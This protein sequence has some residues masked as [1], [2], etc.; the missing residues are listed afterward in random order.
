M[1]RGNY[2][3]ECVIKWCVAVCVFLIVGCTLFYFCQIH[4]ADNV[5]ERWSNWYNYISPFIAIANV[6]AFL[7]LTIAIF[8]GEEQ[9]QKT[10]EQINLQNTIINKL[11]K[12]EVELSQSEKTL[13][14]YHVNIQSIYS[15]YIM[16][17]R[18]AN[19]FKNLPS[20]SI[21]KTRKEEKKNASEVLAQ[22]EKTRNLFIS[23]Y[24]EFR[25]QEKKEVGRDKCKPLAKELNFLIA[26]LEEFEISILQDISINVTNYPEE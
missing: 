16:L 22:I 14:E 5:S 26:Y 24:K 23:I 13:R 19:Y 11:Q 25:E 7:G 3:I 9:R 8:I 18:Y 10:H 6:A 12:I 20:L 17:Y 2:K 15:I 1:A 21:L 4:E